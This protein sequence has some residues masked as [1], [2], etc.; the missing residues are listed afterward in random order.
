MGLDGKLG[1]L[2]ERGDEDF[3]LRA[4]L[5]VFFVVFVG[6]AEVQG[7]GEVID[8]G[9]SNGEGNSLDLD[10]KEEA[11]EDLLREVSDDSDRGLEG[12]ED[13]TGLGVATD[14]GLGD[15]DGVVLSFKRAFG[16]GIFL[17]VCQEV[18][19]KSEFRRGR[20]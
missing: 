20:F 18:L 8:F 10:L 9:E 5:V 1:A 19:R 3:T 7:L 13:N 12:L 15:E 2:G 16:V 11:L 14:C 4:F 6:V 17:E